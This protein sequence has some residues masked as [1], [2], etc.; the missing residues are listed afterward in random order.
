VE[1]GA[2]A[3]FLDAAYVS[4]DFGKTWKKIMSWEQLEAPGSGSSLAGGAILGYG[5][6]IQSW[7]DNGSRSTRRQPTR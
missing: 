3:T 4:A 2:E 6:G 1:L 7:Y 5:P